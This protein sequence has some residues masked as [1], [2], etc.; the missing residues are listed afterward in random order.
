MRTAEIDLK[1]RQDT[2]LM[3]QKIF[4]Q[5]KENEV[6][7]LHQRMYVWMSVCFLILILA[8]F[9]YLYNK[10]QRHLLECAANI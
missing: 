9:I 4:I 8:V 10:K 7:G 2:T 1:Y 5:Q 3:K 6:L